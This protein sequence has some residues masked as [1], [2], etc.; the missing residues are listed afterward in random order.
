MYNQPIVFPPVQSKQTPPT[1]KD[2]PFVQIHNS[3]KI[4][5]EM[6]YPRLGFHHAVNEAYLRY[7]PYTLL[8]QAADKLEK[9]YKLVV[10]DAWRPFSLQKELFEV[11][12][13]DII[14]EFHLE[15]MEEEERIR[16]IS[17]FVAN[18][19]EDRL[20]PPAHTT[21]GAIDM[22]LMYEGKYLDFGTKF[23]EFT[24][25]TKTD[26]FE[27]TDNLTIR[28]NRRFLYHLMT[29]VGFTNLASEWWHYDCGD[30]NY[31]NYTDTNAVYKGV[32]TIEEVLQNLKN[33]TSHYL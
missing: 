3:E 20:Q 13:K 30:F 1:Y 33:K 32:F 27:N 16:F 31:C 14:K 24:D 17:Q 9:G 7:T 12:R 22:T 4:Q 8:L 10:W 15:S 19:N 21:G 26:W 18:P 2:E 5:I 23:D 25:K 29:S 28:N 6:M 11:Y